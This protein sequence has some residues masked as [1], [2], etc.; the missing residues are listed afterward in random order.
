MNQLEYKYYMF[1]LLSM[2]NVDS[3]LMKDIINAETTFAK[4]RWT[5]LVTFGYFCNQSGNNTTGNRKSV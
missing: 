3:A 2:M 1:L 4:A 5:F